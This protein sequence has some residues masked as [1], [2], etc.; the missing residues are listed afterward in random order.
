MEMID[1]WIGGS[2]GCGLVGWLDCLLTRNLEQGNGHTLVV[3]VSMASECTGLT[4]LWSERW[5]TTIGNK[6]LLLLK[7]H[8][9]H[10]SK[11]A[12]EVS[13]IVMMKLRRAECPS[14]QAMIPD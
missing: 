12:T 3:L 8:K 13:R 2:G 10:S 4:F 7:G 14:A 11:K 1:G 5:S 9:A 6:S